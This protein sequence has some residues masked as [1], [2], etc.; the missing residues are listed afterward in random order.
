VLPIKRLD[1]GEELGE[2]GVG[3]GVDGGAEVVVVAAEALS[4]IVEEF[5][6]IERFSRSSEFSSDALQLGKILVGGEIVLACGVEVRAELL[7]PGLGLARDM[8]VR[9]TQT[10]AEESRP[11]TWAS[12]SGNRALTSQRRTC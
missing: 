4:Y 5:I 11:T 6:I 7:D 1:L 9:A 2:G 3:V 10:A 12:T 8:G